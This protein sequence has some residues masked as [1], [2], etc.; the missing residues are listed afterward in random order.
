MTQHTNI[1]SSLFTQMKYTD[2]IPSSKYL[3]KHPQQCSCLF[4]ARPTFRFLLIDLSTVYCRLFFIKRRFDE[5]ILAF[6][7]MHAHWH[8][9]QERYAVHRSGCYSQNM[10]LATYRMF[11]FYGQ[12]LRKCA[13]YDVCLEMLRQAATQLRAIHDA[14]MEH[15]LRMQMENAAS[16]ADGGIHVRRS[17]AGQLNATKCGEK[18]L[19]RS[20]FRSS[21]KSAQ[22]KNK[23]TMI[24]TPGEDVVVVTN[25]KSSVESVPNA[26]KDRIMFE[27]PKSSDKENKAKATTPDIQTTSNQIDSAKSNGAPSKNT[28]TLSDIPPTIPPKKTASSLRRIHTTDGAASPNRRPKTATTKVC[29][30]EKESENRTP[31]KAS[32]FIPPAKPCADRRPLSNDTNPRVINSRPPAVVPKTIRS[33]VHPDGS[34]ES[35]PRATR[36]ASRRAM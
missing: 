27:K 25:T 32:I 35:T 5:S 16:M 28:P 4:C 29:K 11:W 33:R 14:A 23:H 36:S 30:S 3:A 17:S 24:T 1:N 7:Q 31:Q 20:D 2:N 15:E 9:H 12:S 10:V 22:T 8:K 19:M 18:L 26:I 21:E 6:R 34:S 13:K